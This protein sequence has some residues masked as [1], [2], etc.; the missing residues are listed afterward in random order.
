[1][2]NSH[3]QPA[4]KSKNQDQGEAL[5]PYEA[6]IERL[7][8]LLGS[9]DKKTEKDNC[10]LALTDTHSYSFSLHASEVV[11]HNSWV[12]DSGAS[13][14]MTPFFQFFINYNP[15]PSSRK[16]K[17]ADD[18]LITIAS[19]GDVPLNKH[20][21]L[22]NVLQVPKLCTKLLSIQKLIK[23]TNCNVI[24]HSNVCELQE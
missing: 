7:K 10:S 2:A 21:T 24:F 6:E 22:R 13:D 8:G 14:H 19:Q 20:L 11:N 1:M 15:C 17:M 9:L 23:D 12:L 4:P 16:I 3:Q 18:S 5:E